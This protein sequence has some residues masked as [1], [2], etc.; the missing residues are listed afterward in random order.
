MGFL[1]RFSVFKGSLGDCWSGIG[2]HVM[3][4]LF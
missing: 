4:F 1:G 3:W 2:I